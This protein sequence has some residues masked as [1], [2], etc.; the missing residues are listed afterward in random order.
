MVIEF[1]YLTLYPF[2]PNCRSGVSN[3]KFREKNYQVYLVTITVWLKNNP[4]FLGNLDNNA[5][6]VFYSTP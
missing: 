4:P 2:V 5:P 6:G 1:S 3:C